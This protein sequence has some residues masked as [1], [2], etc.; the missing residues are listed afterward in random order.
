MLVA[1]GTDWSGEDPQCPADGLFDPPSS[2]V[3]PLLYNALFTATIDAASLT[4]GTRSIPVIHYEK[5]RPRAMTYFSPI[6]L[7]SRAREFSQT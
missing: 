2:T 4:P 7:C 1:L 3:L 5:A 6:K